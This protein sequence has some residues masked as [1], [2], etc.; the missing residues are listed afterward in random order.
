MSTFKK[1][2]Q[3][4]LELDG[5]QIVALTNKG[6]V[7]EMLGDTVELLEVEILVVDCTKTFLWMMGNIYPRKRCS[8]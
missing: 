7:I 1:F 5:T 2:P 6:I 3:I 4:T 8:A